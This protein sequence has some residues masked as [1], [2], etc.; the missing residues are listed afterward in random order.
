MSSGAMGRDRCSSASMASGPGNRAIRRSNGHKTP[1][2]GAHSARTISEAAVAAELAAA[3]EPGGDS[4]D[5]PSQLHSDGFAAACPSPR[6]AERSPALPDVRLPYVRVAQLGPWIIR[7][8]E[9][10]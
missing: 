4:D 9:R 1:V 6:L 7:S 8:A 3:R 2:N 10:T 5:S